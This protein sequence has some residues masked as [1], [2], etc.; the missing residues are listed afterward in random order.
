MKRITA[1]IGIMVWTQLGFSQQHFGV[2]AGFN[3]AWQ[4]Q[5][6][7][8]TVYP[9]RWKSDVKALAGYEAGFFYH[10]PLAKHWI[11]SA[12][13]NFTLRGVRTQDAVYID[14]RPYPQGT[15]QYSTNKLFYLDIPLLVQYKVHRLTAGAGPSVGLLTKSRTIVRGLYFDSDYKRLDAGVN[16]LAGYQLA[17]KWEV[18]LHYYHGLTNTYHMDAVTA[19]NRFTARNR[20]TNLSLLY[21]LK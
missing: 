17:R 2:K 11:L 13:A 21:T 18:D 20:F 5:Q 8:S 19:Y 9:N 6:Y 1:L 7:A 12:E 4:K 10:V 15:K 16:L 3:T 14:G